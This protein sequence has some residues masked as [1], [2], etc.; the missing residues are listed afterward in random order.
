[1]I[2]TSNTKEI[3]TLN[4]GDSVHIDIPGKEGGGG[5]RVSK[6]KKRSGLF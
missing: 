1:L 2:D 3:H 5:G 4:E 6:R